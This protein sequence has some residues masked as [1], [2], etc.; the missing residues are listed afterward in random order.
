MKIGGGSRLIV[1]EVVQ[2]SA[3]DC[4]PAALKCLLE[5][6]GISVSY[7]RL[8]EACQTDVDGT[9]IDT[10]E[11]IAGQLG[12]DAEQIMVPP[13][14][15]LLEETEALPAIAV[16]EQQHGMTHFVVA[17]RRHRGFMQ[18][19]DPAVG[20]RWATCEQFLSTLYVHTHLVDVSTWREWAT[21]EKF[22][23]PLR[24]KLIDLGLSTSAA[25]DLVETAVADPRWRSLA[26][27]EASTRTVEAIAQ[28]RSL[29]R[30]S[31]AARAVERLFEGARTE[32]DGRE[33]M[34]PAHYW[35]LR[36][37][38][39]G[40][41]GEEQIFFRGAVLVHARGRRQQTG[42][43]D[44][45]E[46]QAAPASL[47]PELTAALE[48]P[49]ARPGLALLRLLAKDGAAAPLSIV[50]ALFFATAGVM[51]EALLFRSLLDLAHEV[52][53]PAQRLAAMAAL[54]AF[55]GVMLALEFP[56][57]T[58]LLGMGRRLES[59]LRIAFLKKI[60]RIGDRYFH[61][62]LNSDM[63]ARS[64]SIHRIRS[65]PSLAGRLLRSTFEL[66]LTAAGIIWLDPGAAPIA[67]VAA[68]LA[69]SL[70]LLVQP[71]L[72][73]RDMRLQNH[74]GALSHYYLDAFLGLMPLRTHRAEGALR[75]EHE[76]LLAVWTHAGFGL[77]RLV[78]FF[79]GMQFFAG[80]G[81]AA[82]LLIDHVSRVSELGSVLL[83]VYWA[84]NLPMLG[85]DIAR[86]AWQ[87][88]TAR[89]LTLRLLELIEAPEE[90]DSTLQAPSCVQPVEDRAAESI[91]GVAIA[92]D[93]VSIRASGHTILE[94]V[95]L[96][97]EAGSHL[98]IVGPS[99]AGKSSLVG[100]LLGW[101]RL[102]SGQVLID[103]APLDNMRLQKLR[104]EIAWVD[105]AI[106]I[107]NRSLFENL[108][109]GSGDCL[110]TPGLL[111][112]TELLDLLQRLPDGLQTELGEN[113]GLVSGGEG[114]RVR[115]GRALLKPG[116]RLAIL[117]EPF[118]GL[119]RQQRR[120][121]LARARKH[122]C[123][124]TLLCVTHD[125][126][127]TLSFPRV[128]VVEAGRIVEDGAPEDLARR[129]ASRY[130]SMLQA[131]EEVRE[132]LWSS[133]IWQR[134]SLEGGRLVQHA[135]KKVEA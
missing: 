116:V 8:R 111:E 44:G 87:Y 109:Y 126:G 135:H 92:F 46:E 20:R 19:M 124:A 27:L 35:S 9:S 117:D 103:G 108:R 81:L 114:Q 86:V 2:T 90:A 95:E 132:G 61:S 3:M 42:V 32:A 119:D 73:E 110:P 67:I 41:E 131:E 17:W 12:L 33:G 22:L 55:A 51:I 97:I 52:G 37:A 98:A 16:V 45:R 84:L 77:E 120:L 127:E 101:N 24:R 107:W 85:Q 71:L 134:L 49:P 31:E 59:R 99:G 10:L 113:G 50:A 79:E 1:P 102:A 6:F 18:V 83:L 130:R 115:L 43:L 106:Q 88:P 80:F 118:R 68:V 53:P 29:R 91:A 26:A 48:E 70:P 94:D 5:G 74:A 7:G 96:E 128:L 76:S 13:D 64:H 39:S 78:V 30:G 28:S 104:Q 25:N 54:V 4:G 63:A 105:P 47:S 75:R 40:P 65:L 129:P 123:E 36:A 66:I 72:A 15:V 14:Y 23:R 56:I 34:I 38:P 82:W 125:V 93:G 62:R 58:G 11:E 133:A 100:I 60:P 112:E 89:N 122:W 21:S 69:V 121:L 57:S